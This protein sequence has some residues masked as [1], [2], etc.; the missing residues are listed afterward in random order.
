[1]KLVIF[2]QCVI[3]ITS[4]PTPQILSIFAAKMLLRELEEFPAMQACAFLVNDVLGTAIPK[5]GTV[6]PA[7]DANSR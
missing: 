6:P 2:R 3:L 4:P 7:W 5:K 1:M